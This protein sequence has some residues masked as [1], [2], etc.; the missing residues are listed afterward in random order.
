M[1]FVI[2]VVVYV[3]EYMDKYF[4][5]SA[6]EVASYFHSCA[7]DAKIVGMVSMGFVWTVCPT[8]A[9]SQALKAHPGGHA[10]PAQEHHSILN[11]SPLS[12]PRPGSRVRQQNTA[13]IGYL[14]HRVP[15]FF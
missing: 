11:G 13:T 12:W 4:A 9:T 14:L 1:T 2:N 3:A 7:L 8:T 15:F 5:C 10:G 6:Q